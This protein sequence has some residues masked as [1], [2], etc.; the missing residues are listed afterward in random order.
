MSRRRKSHVIPPGA[1]M[2]FPMFHPFG[3]STNR[4]VSTQ[5]KAPDG[6][7][8]ADGG[9]IL[10]AEYPELYEAIGTYYGSIGAGTFALPDLRGEFIRGYHTSTNGA[11]GI[12]P[13]Y[14]TRPF[15]SIQS[16]ALLTH[17]HTVNTYHDHTVDYHHHVS[18]NRYLDDA[19]TYVS[20]ATYEGA[21]AA[22]TSTHYGTHQ[23][24]SIGATESRPVNCALLPC[25]K[26]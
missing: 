24:D 18:R 12:D 1:I 7:L 2:Y 21:G 10:V 3:M 8:I 11:S 14:G 6:W 23:S 15:G 16:P 13:D 20:T 4:P 19:V 9:I 17:G 26:Y 5:F 25:I 22:T